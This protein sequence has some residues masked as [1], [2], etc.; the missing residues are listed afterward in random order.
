[1]SWKT[2]VPQQ[3][4]GARGMRDAVMTWRVFPLTQRNVSTASQSG[5]DQIEFGPSQREKAA[6]CM[7]MI[8][9]S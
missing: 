1:L 9:L 8:H 2:N 4:S 6:V 5:A 7:G 3:S